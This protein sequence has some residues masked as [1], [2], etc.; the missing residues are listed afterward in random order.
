VTGDSERTFI[1]RHGDALS[2]FWNGIKGEI[3][4]WKSH[5]EWPPGCKLQAAVEKRNALEQQVQADLK[6]GDLSKDVF[7][8]IM[9]WGFGAGS[10]C[11]GEQ[12]SEAARRAFGHLQADRISEAAKA[13]VELPGIGI[14]RATKVL[15]LSNQNELG[16]YDSRS[17]HGL[18]ELSDAGRQIVPIPPGR[19]IAGD[20]KPPMALCEAFQEYIWVLRYLRCLAKQD[21]VLRTEF[22]R[23]ADIEMALFSK[24]RSGAISLSTVPTT[25]PP[26][27]QSAAEH[28]EESLFWTL[29]S[30]KKAKPFWVDFKGSSVTVRTGAG[31][32][33]KTLDSEQVAACLRHFAGRTFPLSNSKTSA[34]RDPGGLGEYFAQQFRSSVFASHFAALWVHQGWLAIEMRGRVIWLRVLPNPRFSSE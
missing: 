19:V 18:S 32:T 20:N 23:V 34:D 27:L 22:A 6:R 16:I 21:G 33:A 12:I 2:R 28:D 8:S 7:D 29:G 9:V 15:A 5:Y 30:G 3:G 10:R 1:E 31:G 11:S 26:H 17:A 4:K 25:P 24:S 14:S 13:L